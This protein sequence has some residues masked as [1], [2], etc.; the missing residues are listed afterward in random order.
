MRKLFAFLFLFLS[1]PLYI[2]AE[3]EEKTTFVIWA[4]NG[5]K[6]GYV[7]SDKAIIKFLG[8]YLN[9]CINDVEINYP[10]DNL[11]KFTYEKTPETD[12]YNISTN[13]YEPTL[14]GDF[15]LF[16]MLTDNSIIR[17][18]GYDGS[19]IF[20]KR[21]ELAGEYKYPIKNL[22]TGIYIVKVDDITYKIAI[23]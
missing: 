7:L 15:L 22:Y 18:Y 6:V 8:G 20:E 13:K 4:K 17:I 19:L 11:L 16:P 3:T 5:E 12:I 21:I 10:I 2:K 23:K 1:L 9:V 14:N